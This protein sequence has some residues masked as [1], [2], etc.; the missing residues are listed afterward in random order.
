MSRVLVYSAIIGGYDGICRPAPIGDGAKA[1]FVCFTDREMPLPEGVQRRHWKRKHRDPTRDAREIKIRRFEDFKDYD[2]VVW[3]DANCGVCPTAIMAHLDRRG[4]ESPVHVFSHDVRDCLYEEAQWAFS[5]AAD[6]PA[7]VSAQVNRYNREGFPAH[8]GLANTNLL[9]RNPNDGDAI[10]FSND[11]WRE[12][13]RGSRR[14]QLSFDYVRWKTGLKP[15]F[16]PGLW[17]ANRFCERITDHSQ[18]PRRSCRRLSSAL[19]WGRRI[20][21]ADDL[22]REVLYDYRGPRVSFPDKA[23]QSSPAFEPGR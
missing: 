6:S 12:V 10:E 3:A 4:G 9:A 23:K 1:D 20:L 8:Y 17:Y 18:A 21:Q 7:M 11:W 2:W 5:Q 16:F 19:E 15:A 22:F 14:D 13:C